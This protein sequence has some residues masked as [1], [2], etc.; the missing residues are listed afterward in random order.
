MSISLKTAMEVKEELLDNMSKEQAVR[1]L[2]KLRR[3]PGDQSYRD[4]IDL[5]IYTVE[6]S[7]GV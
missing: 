1:L 3:I 6:E 2:M 7:E 5:I 4:S